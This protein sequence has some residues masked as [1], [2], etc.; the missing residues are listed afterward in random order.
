MILNAVIL[1]QINS[2]YILLRIVVEVH[3]LYEINIYFQGKIYGVKVLFGKGSLLGNPQELIDKWPYDP[4]NLPAP[5]APAP[6]KVLCKL[7]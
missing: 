7:Y 3:S 5:P 6:E 2:I 1:F 4:K